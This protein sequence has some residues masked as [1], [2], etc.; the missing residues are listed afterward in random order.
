MSCPK[1]SSKVHVLGLSGMKG[2][3]KD[4]VYYELRNH[5]P[6]VIRIAFG[7]G[8]KEDIS[9]TFGIDLKEMHKDEDYKNTTMS[10]VTWGDLIDDFG[11]DVKLSGGESP[12][13]MLTLREL[14]QVYGTDIKRK[15]NPNVWIDIVKDKVEALKEVDWKNPVLIVITDVRFP[16]EIDL[17]RNELGGEVIY[18]KRRV[19]GDYH[20]EHESEKDISKL[21]S[22]VVRS[23]GYYY[24]EATVND[25]KW[26]IFYFFKLACNRR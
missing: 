20:P 17:I 1:S 23:R 9:Q 26:L 6:N 14:M 8:L 11:L 19:E 4:S 10:G 21:C 25:V 7:D 18:L 22:D 5:Y 13:D 12:Y 16:N 24:K 3:G 2:S 15:E